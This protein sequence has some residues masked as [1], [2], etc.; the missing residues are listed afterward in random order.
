MG[1]T[2]HAAT[3]TYAVVVNTSSLS[4][5]SGSI[6]LQFNPGGTATDAAAVRVFD[7][8]PAASLSGAPVSTG[9]VNGDL[10]TAPVTIR[11]TA[12]Y[13]DYFQNIGFLNQI[14]F[15]VAVDV[16]PSGRATSGSSFVFSLYDTSGITPLLTPNPDGFLLRIDIDPQ[17]NARVTNYN[18]AVL[19]LVPEPGPLALVGTGV[20]ALLLLS[21]KKRRTA[22]SRDEVY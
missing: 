15:S 3:L 7:F 16:T 5:T 4:F 21:R 17:A 20:A 14:A 8:L 19:V 2:V 22:G 11:N 10:R 6:D 13:N 1:A 9:D 12:A 18:P